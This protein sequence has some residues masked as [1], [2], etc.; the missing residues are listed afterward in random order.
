MKPIVL[1][2]C[3]INGFKTKQTGGVDTQLILTVACAASPDTAAQL[4]RRIGGLVSI[5]VASSRPSSD[6][7]DMFEDTGEPPE[8]EE[9]EE[10]EEAEDDEE[11][12]EE[13]EQPVDVVAQG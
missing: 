11:E 7:V 13:E 5:T 10:E 1:S 3:T 12:E 4:V 9:D 8:E 6:T 2:S